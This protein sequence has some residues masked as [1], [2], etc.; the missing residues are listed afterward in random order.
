V[1]INCTPPAAQLST[2]GDGSTVTD[3]HPFL[4]LR[5]NQIPGYYLLALGL[6]LLVSLLF[7]RLSAGK[8]GKMRSYTDLFFMGVAFLLLETM[9]VVRFAL[10][11]G[12]TW[13]VNSL[14]FAGILLAVL[15]AVEVARRVR[16]PQPGILYAALF[17]TLAVAWVIPQSALLS[18]S[19]PVRF[20]L[21][22]MLAF[23]PIFLANVVFAQRFKDAGSS[24][25]AFGANLLGAMVGGVLEYA[26]LVVG[27]RS[28][29]IFAGLLYGLAFVFGRKQ[30]RAT[31]VA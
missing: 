30:L 3:D 5:N 11:F 24:T 6:I 27:Y 2:T 28:L 13:F 25:V 31:I 10:L 18:L 7:V 8:L 19:G 29:L 1:S 17:V 4:Y 21:A 26:A 23:A 16:L 15:A 22:A 14:V 9:N 20:V 12:T